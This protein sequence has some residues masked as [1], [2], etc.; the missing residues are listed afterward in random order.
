[1]EVDGRQAAMDESFHGCTFGESDPVSRQA[2]RRSTAFRPCYS[3]L[4]PKLV[5]MV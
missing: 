2:P 5:V 1:M 4:I 3:T